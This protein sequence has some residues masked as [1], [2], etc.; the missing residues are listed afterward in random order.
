MIARLLRAQAFLATDT[1]R[2]YGTS[3]HYERLENHRAPSS[4]EGVRAVRDAA[5]APRH[6]RGGGP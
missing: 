6:D 3:G 1:M 2:R 5:V 4:P